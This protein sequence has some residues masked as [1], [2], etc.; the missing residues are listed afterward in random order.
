MNF[1]SINLTLI[2]F[3]V[4]PLVVAIFGAALYF[5]IT[6]RRSLQETLRATKKTPLTT[7][8]KES[9]PV[10]KRVTALELEQQFARMRFDTALSRQEKAELPSKRPTQKE[11]MAVQDLKNTIAQQ[12]R[13]LDSYLQ[14]VEQLE[15]EG[16]D[17]L[18]ERI[19]Q[20]E[21]KSDELMA[22]I[23]EKE[24]EI[25]ELHQQA[26]VQEPATERCR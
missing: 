3:I 7:T 23:E 26:G 9:Q 17:E 25:K 15:N 20:L 2:E 8:I 22:V 21:K 16:R 12:Q 4:I 13:M 5:F 6:S 24:E 14:K 1:I 11:E 19:E 10:P 18:N